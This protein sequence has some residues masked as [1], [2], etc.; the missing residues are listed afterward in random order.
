MVVLS[1]L[2]YLPRPFCTWVLCATSFEEDFFACEMND[3]VSLVSVVLFVFFFWYF[4]KCVYNFMFID[5][6]LISKPNIIL[7]V[8]Q[9][10]P[11]I[12]EEYS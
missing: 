2:E 5:A 4:W 6:K 3:D 9:Y 11:Q 12:K 1:T 7:N 10:S 8:Y